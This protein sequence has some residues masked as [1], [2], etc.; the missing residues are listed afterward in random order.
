MEPT[1]IDG[2]IPQWAGYAL[3]FLG[4]LCGIFLMFILGLVAKRQEERGGDRHGGGAGLGGHH[5]D[6][7]NCAPIKRVE[8]GLNA[9]NARIDNLL[10][11]FGKNKGG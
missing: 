9:L 10:L 11:E 2:N 8:F 7:S 1:A 4:A 3:A 6:C 5:P